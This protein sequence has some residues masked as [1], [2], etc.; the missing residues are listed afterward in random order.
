MEQ[1]SGCLYQESCHLK[2]R[3]IKSLRQ[4]SQQCEIE[5]KIELN[6]ENLQKLE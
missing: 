3:L 1:R 5:K 2:K 4:L 6:E